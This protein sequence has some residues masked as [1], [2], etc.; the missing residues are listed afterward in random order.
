M[1]SSC[2]SLIPFLPFI[3]SH[4]GLPPPDLDPIQILAAWDPCYIASRQPHGT[5]R[6]LLLKSVFRFRFLATDALLLRA[7]VLRN[8]FTDPLPS[9]GYTRHNTMSEI[10]FQRKHQETVWAR[11]LK[12]IGNTQWIRKVFAYRS[13]ADREQC[14]WKRKL[15]GAVFL[16]RKSPQMHSARSHL[17]MWLY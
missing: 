15:R 8:V 5:H 13:T 3:L 4:L 17:C 12:D 14:G 7:C 11:V 2:H 9:N 6:L 16:Y 10:Y 1:K